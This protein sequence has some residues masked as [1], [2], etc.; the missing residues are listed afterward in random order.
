MD[1]LEECY[2][3]E[4]R[5]HLKYQTVQKL[6]KYYRMKQEK[7]TPE[8]IF[9]EY[10]SEAEMNENVLELKKHH[11]IKN[12][13]IKAMEEYHLKSLKQLLDEASEELPDDEVIKAFCCTDKRFEGIVSAKWMRSEAAK[14]V[15][16]LK[17]DRR[18]LEQNHIRQSEVIQQLKEELTRR[19]EIGKWVNQNIEHYEAIQRLKQLMPSEQ[20]YLDAFKSFRDKLSEAS[21]T[22]KP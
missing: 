13:I 3:E 11:G 10:F 18:M 7:I 14:T 1:F 21:K 9:K 6:I 5:L 20:C 22:D 12:S 2:K 19:E 17:E 4:E 8:A 16:K 15:V